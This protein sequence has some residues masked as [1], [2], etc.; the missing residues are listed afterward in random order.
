MLERSV[1]IGSYHDKDCTHE[2]APAAQGWEE[3]GEDGMK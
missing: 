3:E 1:E 2:C